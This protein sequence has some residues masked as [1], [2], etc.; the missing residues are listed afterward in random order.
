[1]C[2]SKVD[3]M[4]YNQF[5]RYFTRY[6]HHKRGGTLRRGYGLKE[7]EMTMCTR[8]FNPPQASLLLMVEDDHSPNLP[9]ATSEECNDNDCNYLSSNNHNSLNRLK[10][11][12]P[13]RSPNLPSATSEECKN[14]PPPRL[15]LPPPWDNINETT[16][17]KFWIFR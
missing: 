10:N 17:F 14:L 2:S 16:V 1:M 8:L 13:H 7:Q 6:V 4:Y 11:L 5:S 15:S 12:P 3:G 9:S